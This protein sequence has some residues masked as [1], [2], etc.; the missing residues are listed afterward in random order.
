[1]I[2]STLKRRGCIVQS[3]A[4]AV[5]PDAA[6]GRSTP[7]QGWGFYGAVR[8]FSTSLPINAPAEGAKSNAYCENRRNSESKTDGDANRTK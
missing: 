5:R 8:P 1:M 3:N 6:G 2:R 4:L 7:A